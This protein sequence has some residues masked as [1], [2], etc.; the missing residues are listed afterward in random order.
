MGYGETVNDQRD[1]AGVRL[2]AWQPEDL[3]RRLDDAIEVYGQ[4]RDELI[5]L[6]EWSFSRRT[7]PLTLLKGP[8]PPGG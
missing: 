2:V 6:K 3:T 8:P 5:T 1:A 7:A 4:A